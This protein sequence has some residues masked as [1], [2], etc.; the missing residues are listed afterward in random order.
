MVWSSTAISTT[1]VY[2]QYGIAYNPYHN[3]IYQCDAWNNYVN[4]FDMSITR[5]GDSFQPGPWGFTPVGVAFFKNAVDSY[6][7]FTASQNYLVSVIQSTRAQVNNRIGICI[8]NYAY[9]IYID[10]TSGYT[11][12]SCHWDKK[13]HIWITN[14][15]SHFRTG[16]YINTAGNPSGVT[17]DSNGRLLIAMASPSK[18]DVYTPADYTK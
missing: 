10:A 3:L 5:T 8:S 14:G 1:Y 17:M 9:A 11:F 6:I 7:I 4:A 2:Q 16:Y 13:V 15:T 18:I 12:L